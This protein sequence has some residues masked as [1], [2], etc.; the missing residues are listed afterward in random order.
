MGVRAPGD[1]PLSEFRFSP[2][3]NRA[4]EINWRSWGAAAFDE[5]AAAGRPVFLNLTAVWCH[6]CHVMDETTLSDPVI[7]SLIND[8]LVAVRVDADRFPHVQDR[9]IAG[10]WPTNAFLT[11]TG[12]VLWAGT[13]IDAAEFKQ[14]AESVLGAWGARRAELEAEIG[15]R[16]RALDAARGRPHNLG[17]VR[18]EAADDI[19]TAARESFDARNGGFG[20]APKF[21]NTD[22]IELLYTLAPEDV[23]FAA[24]ADQTLDG[25]LAGALWDSV[26]GGFFRYATAADWTEPRYEK[27]LEANAAL[28]E[29]YTCGAWLRGREDWCAIVDRTVAW[30][31]VTLAGSDGLWGGSQSADI[32]YFNA[33]AK[34]RRSLR[35]PPVDHTVFTAANARWIGALALAGARLNRPLWVRRA[36]HALQTLLSSMRAPDGGFYHFRS[37]DG[38]GQA[39]FLFEDTLQCGRAVLAVAQATGDAPLLDEARRIA[40]YMEEK[41]W[42][43]DGAFWDRRATDHDVGALQYR[44]RPFEPNAEAARFLIDLVHLTGE[45]G[46]RAHAERILARLGPLAGRYGVAGAVF[47]HA[48]HE[49]FEAPPRV[50]ITVPPNG[51][52]DDL[53]RAAAFALRVPGLRVWTVPSGHSVGPQSFIAKD[54]AAAFVWTRRG[55]SGPIALAQ[56]LVD[57]L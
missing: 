50:F 30:V 7:I 9:Y 6:W 14:V 17:L 26:E 45:R 44:D 20:D 10:G 5:A 57:G 11:P 23:S 37:E 35:T 43:D 18:R 51:T 32:E 12:D 47:A 48:V 1:M 39:D 54:R 34:Q 29:A 46:W 28:L 8:S 49:F 52:G 27:L 25:M 40:R 55:C 31:E 22:A 2:R 33:A 3:P 42:A 4:A 13:L 19:V 16:R 21:T 41:F 24:M 56:R 53:L 38:A 15:R 36:T